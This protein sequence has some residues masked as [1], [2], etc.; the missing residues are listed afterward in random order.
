MWID[1]ERRGLLGQPP[2]PCSSRPR[3]F[4]RVLSNVFDCCART[5]ST[6]FSDCRRDGVACVN[7]PPPCDTKSRSFP[8]AC[9]LALAPGMTMEDDMV[10]DA[11]LWFLLAGMIGFIA[12]G[13]HYTGHA[14]NRYRSTRDRRTG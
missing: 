12:C 11:V 6:I 5:L 13:C 14:T 9:A 4:N 1:R 8:P 7:A 10:T 2:I 3:R